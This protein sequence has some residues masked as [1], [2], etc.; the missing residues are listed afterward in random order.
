MLKK[1][2]MP[3]EKNLAGARAKTLSSHVLAL[4]AVYNE[5]YTSDYYKKN[6]AS[7]KA[8][9]KDGRVSLKP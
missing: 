8:L 9:A 7:A 5:S 1:P 4:L 3:I 2:P 6:L